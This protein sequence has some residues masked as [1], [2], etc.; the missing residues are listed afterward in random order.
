MLTVEN[1]A[2]RYR[3]GALGVFD[4]SL[5]VAAHQVVSVFGPNGAG[6]TTTVRAISGFLRT[7]KA[8]VVRGRVLFDGRDISNLEPHVVARM[9]IGF[10]AERDKVFPHL[11][12]RENLLAVGGIRGKWGEAREEVL[13]FF[14]VLR[15]RLKSPA[16]QLSG[17]QR[18]MLAIARAMTRRPRLLIVDE[19]T[20]GLHVS[21]QAQLFDIMKRVCE[22]GTAVLLVDESVSFALDISD[23]CYLI[24]D[25]H[26]E[27]SGKPATFRG[28]EM[29]AAGYSDENAI[30]TDDQ[31][32]QAGGYHVGR[33]HSS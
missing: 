15:E 20:L 22:T 30:R 31:P 24:R 16:G 21:V 4:V 2:V 6:K 1:L 18:Q 13:E 26:V 25:G 29:A 28:S 7:E 10:V 5:E 14:P 33:T 8:R 17:G 12:V 11:S 27:E 32:G 19:M 23:H 3:N 9:G